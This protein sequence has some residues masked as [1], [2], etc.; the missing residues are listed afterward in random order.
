MGGE[1]R[2]AAEVLVKSPPDE[3]AKSVKFDSASDDFDFFRIGS[4]V[5][6]FLRIAALGL[7][8]LK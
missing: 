5:A 4:C 8:S 2:D 1:V 7:P 3:E 6:V